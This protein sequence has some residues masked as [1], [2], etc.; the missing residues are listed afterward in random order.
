MSIYSL[1][2]FG[3]AYGWRYEAERGGNA[4]NELVIGA[5]GHHEKLRIV[6]RSDGASNLIEFR[7]FV[8]S[9]EDSHGEEIVDKIFEFLDDVERS[10]DVV[11][12]ESL[13]GTRESSDLKSLSRSRTQAF[14][15][16]NKLAVKMTYLDMGMVAGWLKHEMIGS[17]VSRE[18]FTVALKSTAFHQGARLPKCSLDA[19][20]WFDA[21]K[22]RAVEEP[23]P[24]WFAPAKPAKWQAEILSRDWSISGEKSTGPKDLIEG[25]PFMVHPTYSGGKSVFRVFPIRLGHEPAY[26][27][28]QKC[29]VNIHGK[30]YSLLPPAIEAICDFEPGKALPWRVTE[31]RLDVLKSITSP[32]AAA[33]ILRA[34]IG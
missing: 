22:H 31:E 1:T 14:R 21:V 16:A 6:P 29:I 3:L 12:V 10:Y 26:P 24:T 27:M 20:G 9:I 17:T 5:S 11:I 19:R 18:R 25:K 30:W 33:S 23:D 4:V 2:T 7:V 28:L 15:V 13:P 8:A 32:R 34:N